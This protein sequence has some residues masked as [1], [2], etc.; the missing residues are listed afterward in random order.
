MDV[1]ANVFPADLKP[2]GNSLIA[3]IAE[4]SVRASAAL[5]HGWLGLAVVAVEWWRHWAASY[6]WPAIRERG[7]GV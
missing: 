5:F 7:L 2:T 1:S 6:V 3:P 4:A